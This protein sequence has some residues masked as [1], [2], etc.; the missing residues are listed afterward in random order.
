MTILD[1]ER[2]LR[3][4]QVPDKSVLERCLDANELV[5]GQPRPDDA[6]RKDHGS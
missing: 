5:A 3:C 2:L 6:D 4:M 1:C